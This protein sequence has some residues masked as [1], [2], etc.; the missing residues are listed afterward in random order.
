MTAGD[1]LDPMH[2]DVD[3]PTCPRCGQ[4]TETTPEGRI[5]LCEPSPWG[6]FWDD[7]PEEFRHSEE[8]PR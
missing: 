7:P 1:G 4:P 3:Y 6:D 5:C 2:P 8:T